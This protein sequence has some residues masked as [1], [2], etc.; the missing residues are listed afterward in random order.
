MLVRETSYYENIEKKEKEKL[1][2]K[3]VLSLSN[4][5]VQKSTQIHTNQVKNTFKSPNF[6]IKKITIKN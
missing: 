6:L 3:I 5:H 1:N 4:S 2:R